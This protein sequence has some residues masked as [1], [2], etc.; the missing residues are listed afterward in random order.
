M[1]VEHPLASI[2]S[3]LRDNLSAA[4]ITR[5]LHESLQHSLLPPLIQLVASYLPLGWWLGC[6]PYIL[7]SN[8]ERAHAIFEPGAQSYCVGYSSGGPFYAVDFDFP[9]PVQVLTDCHSLSL[10][11][12]LTHSRS[13]S[14]TRSPTY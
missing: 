10:T 9:L 14:V 5:L 13:H 6:L 4:T 7:R 1:S 2:S 11:N 8:L 12:S 3:Q